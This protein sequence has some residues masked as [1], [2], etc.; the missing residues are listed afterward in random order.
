MGM[1]V[2]AVQPCCIEGLIG[3]IL[4]AHLGTVEQLWIG[5]S[6]FAMFIIGLVI[7]YCYSK[8]LGLH[9]GVSP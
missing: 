2:V 9:E 5:V 3:G 6:L 8:S 1:G 7:Y 4:Q